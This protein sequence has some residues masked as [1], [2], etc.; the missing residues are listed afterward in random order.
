MK[1]ANKLGVI[2]AGSL[3]LVVCSKIQVSTSS[4]VSGETIAIGTSSNVETI[5][6]FEKSIPEIN[7]YVDSLTN[8]EVDSNASMYLF[9][10]EYYAPCLDFITEDASQEDIEYAILSMNIMNQKY[11]LDLSTDYPIV[12]EYYKMIDNEAKQKLSTLEYVDGSVSFSYEPYTNHSQIEQQFNEFIDEYYTDIT[13]EKVQ[14]LGY[15]FKEI[16][17]DNTISSDLFFLEEE[18]MEKYTYHYNGLRYIPF[19]V[20]SLNMW[21]EDAS[22]DK[23]SNKAMCYEMLC[24]MKNF[25]E[26]YQNIVGENPDYVEKVNRYIQEYSSAYMYVLTNADSMTDEEVYT[27]LHNFLFDEDMISLQSDMY[28]VEETAS[29]NILTVID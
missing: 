10:V 19:R 2:L 13:E 12:D 20:N 23:Q 5:E 25:T 15:P 4:N 9:D 29:E 27:Y 8:N 28:D 1:Y 16:T 11:P 3:A 17:V 21:G 6:T 26:Q 18:C 7:K 14:S 24:R 22:N